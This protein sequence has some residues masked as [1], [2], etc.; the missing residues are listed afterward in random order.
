MIPPSAVERMSL[1]NRQATRDR[2]LAPHEIVAIWR[3]ADQN[4]PHHARH[5]QAVA[6]LFKVLLLLG[7]T[8]RPPAG[9]GFSPARGQRR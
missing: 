4:A 8:R 7:Q 3:A 6:A 9:R 2:V 1:P 5:G